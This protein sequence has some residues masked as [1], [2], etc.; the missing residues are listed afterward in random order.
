M[1]A[2]KLTFDRIKKSPYK[3]DIICIKGIGNI[4]PRPEVND[5]LLKL[6]PDKP[7]RPNKTFIMTYKQ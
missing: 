1:K 2:N 5:N 3:G 7:K 6:Y 4:K